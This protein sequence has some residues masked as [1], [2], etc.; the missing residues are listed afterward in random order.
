MDKN[1]ERVGITS[2]IPVEIIY[3][4]G[5]IPVDVNNVFIGSQNPSSLVRLAKREGFPDTTCS[6][7]CGLYGAIVERE[8]GT[9]IGVTGGDCS[10]TIGLMEVLSLR[11]VNVIPFSYPYNRDASALRGEIDRL[12]RHFGVD[13]KQA[14]L[15]KERLDRVRVGIHRLDRLLWEEDR[16]FGGEVQLLQL[17]SSDFEGDP[18]AYLENVERKIGQVG[19]RQPIPTELRLGFVG[20]PPIISD[21]YPSIE[22][23]GVRIVLSEVQ[24]QFSLPGGGDI[25][26]AF[27][28]YTYPYGIFA[29]AE[30][31]ALEIERRRIDGIIHYIQAFCFRGIEDIALRRSL[32]VPVLTL[33]GDLPSRVTETMRLRIEA[34][35]DMLRWRKERSR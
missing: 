28:R 35:V 19:A 7:I 9:V 27:I 30:D 16:A 12:A 8:I 1:S 23:D 2:T 17:G 31:I 26:E 3:A 24:R 21:L 18:E 4:A 32:K 29:R 10:E 14:E 5:K 25:V 20:V 22:R 6:W 13:S 33:Q 15:Q 34:F 11:G